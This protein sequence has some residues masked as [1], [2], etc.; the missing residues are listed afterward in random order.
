MPGVENPILRLYFVISIR[1]LLFIEKRF[2]GFVHW[3]VKKFC[4][5]QIKDVALRMAEVLGPNPCFY[6]YFDRNSLKIKLET[7]SFR[8]RLDI[9]QE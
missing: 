9:L 3:K 1:L 4:F 2:N 5:L 8:E 6:F 7:L